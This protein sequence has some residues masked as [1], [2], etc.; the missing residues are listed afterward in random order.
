MRKL[1]TH[2]IGNANKRQWMSLESAGYEEEFIN[3]HLELR[4]KDGHQQKEQTTKKKESSDP[5]FPRDFLN[6]CA[7]NFGVVVVFSSDFKMIRLTNFHLNYRGC[8]KAHR[9][10]SFP[11]TRYRR[12]SSMWDKP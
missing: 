5:I 6:A 7:K 12:R 3:R 1:C 9:E 11:R 10:P 8:Q 2:F 4:F